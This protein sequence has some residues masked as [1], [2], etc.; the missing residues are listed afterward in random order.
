[1]NSS[2]YSL[3]W[4]HRKTAG[5]SMIELMT[6]IAIMI[7]LA[8]IL[9][10]SL[11]GIQSKVNRNRVEQFMAELKGG[12][13]TYQLDNGIYPQNV[14]SGNTQ[15]DRD[16]AGL[17][18]SKILYKELS[19]DRDLDGEVDMAAN[20]KVYVQRLSY[21]ENKNSKN[22]RSTAI[23]GDFQ[24]VDSYGDPIRYLAQ[25]PNIVEKDRLTF[26]PDYDLWSIAGSDP[27]DMA[28]QAAHITNW[29]SN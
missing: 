13:S 23:G 22:P 18:G 20:E 26:N 1:M 11:P 3:R 21:E 2:L 6:V 16:T 19:G 17:E 29:Q 15:S 4:Q 12:L 28:S 27:T 24:V 14:P 10:A 9:L 5:F 25:P 8:G 7:L